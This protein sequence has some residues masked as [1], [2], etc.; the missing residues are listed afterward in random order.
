MDFNLNPVTLTILSLGAVGKHEDA[1]S[2]LGARLRISAFEDATRWLDPTVL[3][4]Q[5]LHEVLCRT[6]AEVMFNMIPLDSSVRMGF[7]AWVPSSGLDNFGTRSKVRAITYCWTI[8]FP[9]IFGNR[10][11]AHISSNG[12]FI[13]RIPARHC[14]ESAQL[15]LPSWSV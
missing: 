8:H 13:F 5:A 1:V 14:I 7:Q 3:E 11:T 10:W 12:G 9:G 4:K 2:A 15:G 6:G